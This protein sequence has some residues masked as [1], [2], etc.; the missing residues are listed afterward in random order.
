MSVAVLVPTFR[1]NDSLKRALV[2]VF[3]QTRTPDRIVVADNSPEGGARALLDCLNRHSPCPLVYVHAP[4]PGVASARNAG[5]AACED[6]DL[7]A[8]LDDDE[9]AEPQWL[10]AL[11]ASAER[12]GAAVVFGPVTPQAEG[13]GPVRTAWLRRL[14]ARLPALEDGLIEKPWGCGNSLIVKAACAL[15][16]PPFDRAADETGGEDDRLFSILKAKGA[17][18]AWTSD[19]Q[20]I[21]HVDPVRGRWAALAR[22]AFAFGQGPSQDAAEHGRWA[23]LAAW[24]GVGVA[25]ALIF[26][27]AA[28]AAWFLG[29][30]PCAACI[31][32]AVQGAGKAIWMDRFAPRF[33]GAALAARTR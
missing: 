21:E 9:S 27:A 5:F 7:I 17:S 11:I 19:A 20:A 28:P 33:Y 31:D 16:V 10:A 23:E 30:A 24:M 15:P 13:A 8:Q 14:Y 26:A 18:F 3:A 1:R 29:A 2:S 6:M 32:R 22:R 12:S 25:Q 4:N